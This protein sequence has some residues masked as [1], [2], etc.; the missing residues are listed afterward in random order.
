MSYTVSTAEY[1]DYL[2]QMFGS[3]LVSIDKM[4]WMYRQAK[5]KALQCDIISYE[6][7]EHH[8]FY[9]TSYRRVRFI[10]DTV[11]DDMVLM[12]CEEWDGGAEWFSYH[13]SHAYK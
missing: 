13:Y 3:A 11:A 8:V 2:E 9:I 4:R 10:L 7:G 5:A 1:V 12:E 6:D